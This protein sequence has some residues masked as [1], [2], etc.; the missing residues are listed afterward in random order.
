MIILL[1]VIIMMMATVTFLLV[2]WWEDAVVPT[3]F[4]IDLLL[5]TLGNC[6]LGY[7]DAHTCLY[8]AQYP[9]V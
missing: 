3:H 1:T 2:E 4:E 6:P 5:N 8:G 7:D 9:T